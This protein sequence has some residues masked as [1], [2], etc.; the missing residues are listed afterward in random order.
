MSHSE[1]ELYEEQKLFASPK[2]IEELMQHPLIKQNHDLGT[3]T[4]T[5]MMYNVMVKEINKVIT[6]FNLVLKEI[7]TSKIGH[8]PS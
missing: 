7:E 2:D 8:S 4:C 3:V 1:I 5:M 6:S